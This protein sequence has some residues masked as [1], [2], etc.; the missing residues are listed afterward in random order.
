MTNMNDGKLLEK[1]NENKSKIRTK[2][3][4]NTEVF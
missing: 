3:K 1:A 4:F 2:A